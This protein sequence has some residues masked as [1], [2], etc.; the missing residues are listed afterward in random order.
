MLVIVRAWFFVFGQ[1]MQL[2]CLIFICNTQIKIRLS[3]FV[4]IAVMISTNAMLQINLGNLVTLL[5]V[6]FTT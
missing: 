4:R 5:K 2:V 3:N 6:L 1:F